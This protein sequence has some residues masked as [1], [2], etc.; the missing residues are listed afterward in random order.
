MNTICLPKSKLP[1]IVIIGSGFAGFSFIKAV[2]HKLFQIV[3]IDQNNFHQFQPLL[4]QVATCGIEPD[5]I[6]F[7]VR[8]MFEKYENFHFRLATVTKIDSLKNILHTDIGT[9]SYD[10]LI[11]ATGSCNNFFGLQNVEKY[12]IGM[13][14]IQEALDIRSF[15]LQN[16][17]TADATCVSKVR[18]SLL[19][20][21]IVGGGPTGVEMA[22]ALAEFKNYIIPKDY[23]ELDLNEIKI[24][25]IESGDRL[26]KAMPENLS[27]KSLKYLQDMGV[28]IHLNTT[29]ADYKDDVIT[30]KKGDEF[31]C[32]TLIWTAGVKG[33]VIDGLPDS[34]IGRGARI[35]VDE[36]FKV[37]HTTNIFA[38]GDIAAQ[39]N[40]RTPFGHP[41]VAPAAIQ[42]GK[43]LGKNF[44][45]IIKNQKVKPFEYYDKGSMSTI[46]RKR[47]V[48]QINNK[49]YSGYIAWLLWS[50]VHL[51]SISGFKNKI[52]VGL[53]WVSSYFTY[54]KS[55]RFIIRK[56][57]QQN[58]VK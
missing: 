9:I 40:E 19:H 20:F 16:L 39:I 50:V 11:I 27:K 5:S 30:T 1:R 21:V 45:N 47:A 34:V 38:I 37:K 24:S 53:D 43:W 23:P 25:L 6:V 58:K 44:Q 28:E 54:E 51:I 18:K 57:H 4:Y 32:K 14:T 7:P 42:Q 46:G 26:L 8:K 13:K 31:I 22:G 29:V 56:F 35:L 41:Q 15:I 33:N 3:L 55:N 36:D 10:Y 12:A 49:Q 52:M 48:A 2:N 17:E